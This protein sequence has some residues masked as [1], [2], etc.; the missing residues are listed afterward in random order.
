MLVCVCVCVFQSWRHHRA[1]WRLLQWALSDLCSGIMQQ[2]QIAGKRK[3]VETKK[4]RRRGLIKRVSTSFVKRRW[5]RRRQRGA[6]AGGMY[7]QPW[8][9][10]FV[11]SPWSNVYIFL[12]RCRHRRCCVL[13]SRFSSQS[14]LGIVKKDGHASVNQ[15]LREDPFAT[16]RLAFLLSFL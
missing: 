15:K 12:Q 9:G 10:S 6:A 8:L 2:P 11:I 14:A 4:Y 5:R 13:R 16:G 7:L 3:K 1:N